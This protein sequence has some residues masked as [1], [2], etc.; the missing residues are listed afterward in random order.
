[1]KYMLGCNYWGSA[2]GTEMWANWD[3]Q[4]VE[5]D[6][7][8]LK[9][10]GVSTMRVFPNWRDFQPLVKILGWRGRFHEYRL[11]GKEPMKDEF[12]LDPLMMEHFRDFLDLCEKH[13][14]ELV[15]SIV[16]GWM[17]GRLFLPPAVDD[18]NPIT[19]PES[20]MLQVK[21]VRGFVRAFCDRKVIVAWDL[22]NE[23]NCLGISPS[24][25]ASYMW[26]ATVAN[27]IRS[28]DKSRPIHSGMH[29][30]SAYLEDGSETWQIVDQ[31]ENR[32]ALSVHPYPSPTV[33]G[34]RD[35][36]NCLRTS[37]IP[38]AQMVY[39]SS[40][41]QKPAMIQEQGTFNTMLGNN[42]C[43]ADFLRV[44]VFSSFAN[45][46]LGYFWWCAHEQL[47]LDFPPY[48]WSMVE[49]ELGLLHCDRSPKPA[50]IEMKRIAEI[51]NNLPIDELPPK[52]ADAVC[53]TTTGNATWWNSAAISYI[54]AKEAGL[55]PIFACCEYE[56]PDAPVYFVPSACGWS[57][58][59][60]QAYDTLLSRVENGAT[61]YISTDTA[62]FTEAEKVLGLRSNGIRR[63]TAPQKVQFGE[64]ILAIRNT[65]EFMMQPLTAEV[66]AR[67]E[68]GNVI[69]SRNAYGKGYV[70]YLGFPLENMLWNSED[71]MPSPDA[72]PYY[73]IYR[74]VAERALAEKPIYAKTPDIGI[75]VHPISEREVLATAINYSA[76]NKPCDLCIADGWKIADILYGSK[77][78]LSKGEMVLLRLKK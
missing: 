15:V 54:L 46:G 43:S 56:I 41:G 31:A 77:E 18:K 39:Y 49:R 68:S 65:Q 28:E 24:R 11:H 35:P 67:D 23:C 7:I 75:T 37:M 40:I 53:V 76:E 55:D 1:M 21:F 8:A 48:S 73:K 45:G 30:L 51:L 10:H 50:A 64:D 4:S 70:Y 60:K 13:G 22:G 58:M 16:T 19:D 14:I 47:H 36:M 42:D 59:S 5:E 74:T 17:S 63:H 66:L 29:A 38:T 52:K 71:V 44:N 69:F 27:A 78:E 20:L 26:T 25:E 3:A 32:D 62:L 6:L 61:L 9:A 72:Y 2:H 34:D 33:G 12:G 57:C